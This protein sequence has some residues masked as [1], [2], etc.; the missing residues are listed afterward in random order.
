MRFLFDENMPRSFARILRELGYDAI[1]VIDVGL[2]ATKRP[3]YSC[4]C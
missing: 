4:F 3:H 1:H 2:T